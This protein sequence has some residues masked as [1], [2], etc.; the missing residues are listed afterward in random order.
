MLADKQGHIGVHR[1][2]QAGRNYLGLVL[3]V[4]RMTSEQMRGLG[5]V[6]RRAAAEGVEI[7]RESRAVAASVARETN[8]ASTTWI[9][10][11]A[12]SSA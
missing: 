6:R 3:P 5:F 4:G 1:Q 8:S 9:L 2:K 12:R 7:R 10:A 11:P